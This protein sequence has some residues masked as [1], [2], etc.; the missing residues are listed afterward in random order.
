MAPC[1]RE[2][3]RKASAKLRDKR[4]ARL[5]SSD[6]LVAQAIRERDAALATADQIR[7][8]NDQT[9]ALL[10]RALADNWQ[11]DTIYT[12]ERNLYLTQIH[13]LQQQLA[14]AQT[15]LATA[16]RFTCTPTPSPSPNQ[17]SAF[18]TMF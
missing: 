17:H 13:G 12:A 3:N 4:K 15:M 9:L 2:T 5:D 7:V 16:A 1:R 8:Q 10:E 18:S 6:D 14:S 11:A